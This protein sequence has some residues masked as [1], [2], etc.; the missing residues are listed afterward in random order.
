MIDAARGAGRRP[1]ILY[2]CGHTKGK[3]APLYQQHPR[4]FACNGYVA[5]VLDPIQLGESQGV[6][7]GTYF[8][9]RWDWISR[10]YTPAGTEVWNAMR[11]LDYL[12]T[13]PDVDPA[14]L[15]VT[16]ISGGGAMSWFLGAAD[17]RVRCVVPVCQTGSI[18]RL[19]ADRTLDGHCDCACW[20]NTRQW[21]TPDVGALI[22]PR[23][24]LIAAGTEDVLWRPDAFREAAYRIRRQYAALGAADQVELVEDLCPHGYTPRLRRA[25]LEWFNLHLKG[26]CEPAVGDVTDDVEPERNLLVFGGRPPA[27]DA[28]KRI[29]RILPRLAPVPDAGRPGRWRRH[30]RAALKRLRETAF[31]HAPPSGSAPGLVGRRYLGAESDQTGYELLQ[32]R[33]ADG[34]C[35]RARRTRIPGAGPQAPLVVFALPPEARSGAFLAGRPA[36]RE[37]FETAGIEV[38][39]TGDTS[40]GPGCLWHVRRAYP[41]FG[42]SLP[43]RQISDWLDG[44]SV[45]RRAVGRRPC[46][47][48]GKGAGA[49][50][51]LYTALLDPAVAEIIVDSPP[52]S[53]GDPATPELPGILKVGDLPQNLALL[54]PR[55]I[56]FV[57]R[58]PRAYRWTVSLYRA[59]G[60][61]GRIRRLAALDR[62]R[63]YAAPVRRR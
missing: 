36:F 23:A 5:L 47:L 32:F 62:W 28:M 43:E 1:A 31:R 37:R 22:A 10:G 25:V 44:L 46:V 24:L 54:F 55:P 19:V 53:H 61:P 18:A 42:Q 21:C 57:G 14:R 51:A 50:L 39:N 26:R 29:D 59:L 9:D 33:V 7:H 34:L 3:V 40:V 63:P 15:G 60:Q 30:Q 49:V 45:L 58:V 38:R 12:Q 20:I 27:R 2:L 17:P 4:W 52:A 6:H 8:Y 48:Y 16:G 11:A 13:R 35:L 41:L 56:A